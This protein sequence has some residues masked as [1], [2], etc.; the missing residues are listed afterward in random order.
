MDAH[1][2][3]VNF[4]LLDLLHQRVAFHQEDAHGVEWPALKTALSEQ[5]TGT[6]D[7]KSLEQRTGNAA[8][9]VSEARKRIAAGEGRAQALVVLSSAVE[10]ESGEDLKPIEAAR[11]R[12][13]HVFYIRFPATLPHPEHRE[14]PDMAHGGG[15][16]MGG[17]GSGEW[18]RPGTERRDLQ[19]DQLEATLKPLVPRVFNIET[20]EDFRKALAAI[21]ADIS[22]M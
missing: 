22:R 1:P 4:V 16:H 15:H 8:F 5:D 18:R 13:C 6:I 3:L 20:Q 9:F 7:I 10:F 12:D 21:L 19:I 17:G 11:S 2:G 14:R